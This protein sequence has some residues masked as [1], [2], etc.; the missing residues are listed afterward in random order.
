MATRRSTADRT[1]TATVPSQPIDEIEDQ[2]LG[3]D[4]PEEEPA[5]DGPTPPAGPPTISVDKARQVGAVNAEAVQSNR[6]RKAVLDRKRDGEKHVAW[7]ERDACLLYDDIVAIWPPHSLV[8]HVTRISGSQLAWYLQ[9]QPRNGLELYEAIRKQCHGRAPETEYQVVFRDSA[10]REERGRARVLLPSTEFEVDAPSAAPPLPQ[11]PPPAAAASPPQAPNVPP[12]MPPMAPPGYPPPY[13]YP[14][15]PPPPQAPAPPAAPVAGGSSDPVVIM[16][17]QKQLSDIAAQNMA[18]QQQLAQMQS[19]VA[20][21][22]PPPP[23]PQV[24]VREAAP[25]APMPFAQRVQGPSP[26]APPP[27]PPPPAPVMP[28][29]AKAPP[30]PDGYALTMLNGMPVLVP[31]ASLGIGV[32][33]APVPAAA[34]AAAPAS[35]PAAQAAPAAA[36]AAAPQSPIEQFQAAIGMVKSVVAASQEI[37]SI[38]GSVLPSAPGAPVGGAAEGA[39]PA[40]EET[41]TKVV[42][43]GEMH[44]VQNK[45]DGSVRLVDT[46]VANA[47]KIMSWIDTQRKEWL[48]RQDA[49]ARGQVPPTQH[50]TQDIGAPPIPGR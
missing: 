47:P 39:E 21:P 1:P 7:G 49:I 15:P 46:A 43:M 17:L 31:L 12:M 48:A 6:R 18:L 23:P 32:A 4:R 41:P 25:Q 27:P 34:P 3:G 22:P 44:I 28:E 20:Q 42:K 29:P 5:D 30:V 2:V 40:E 13:G 11:A 37:Q 26:Y 50:P 45:E 10:R 24:I 8:I 36:P 38:A 33:A 35:A 14:P 9:A 19:R 16:Q